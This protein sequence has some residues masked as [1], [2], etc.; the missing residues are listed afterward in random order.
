VVG[1]NGATFYITG[2]QL[3]VGPVATQF[4]YRQYQTELALCQ[5][6]Y[7]I[8][9][10]VSGIGQAY[11]STYDGLAL[12]GNFRVEKRASPTVT[13]VSGTAINRTA[14]SAGSNT[15]T[16][17]DVTQYGFSIIMQ[18]SSGSGIVQWQNGV[19]TAEIEL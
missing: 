17:T 15:G 8:I 19:Y 12:G 5:R 13:K 6:Y 16:P 10:S 3:E 14:G 7:E 1:T 2:V 4:E 9:K 11:Y 18:A